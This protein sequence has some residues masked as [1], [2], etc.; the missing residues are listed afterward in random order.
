MCRTFSTQ[1]IE[2]C[3][4]VCRYSFGALTAWL[5]RR[6]PGLRKARASAQPPGAPSTRR[7]NSFVDSHRLDTSRPWSS[8]SNMSHH[9][10]QSVKPVMPGVRAC[11]A[12]RALLLCI[13]ASAV[14]PSKFSSSR[15][16]KF[17]D[18][19][20][21]PRATSIAGGQLTSDGCRLLEKPRRSALSECT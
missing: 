6:Q 18:L 3:K 2:R 19:A 13:A 12:A 8:V 16:H 9:R 1:S 17:V 7:A 15:V 14:V 5:E 10:K 21:L 4:Q 20:M 11:P